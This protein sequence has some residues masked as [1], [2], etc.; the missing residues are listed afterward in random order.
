MA[1]FKAKVRASH[2]ARRQSQQ[3][4]NQATPPE[5]PT[6]Q[7]QAPMQLLDLPLETLRQIAASLNNRAF[8]RLT[9]TCRQL[10]YMACSSTAFDRRAFEGEPPK[11]KRSDGLADVIHEPVPLIVARGVHLVLNA[12]VAPQYLDSVGQYNT[13]LTIREHSQEQL[14][15]QYQAREP[16]QEHA[17]GQCQ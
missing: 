11:L 10:R 8:V 5:T 6:P 12:P 16:D 4:T 9:S 13:G 3:P 2:Q 7:Q 14:Q 1:K 15:S 17:H